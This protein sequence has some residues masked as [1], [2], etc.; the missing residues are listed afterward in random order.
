MEWP[1]D[2]T[3][4]GRFEHVITRT[5]PPGALS[6]VGDVDRTIYGLQKFMRLACNGNPSIIE[7][8]YTR[9][10][11]VEHPLAASLVVLAP[12]IVS[13]QAIPCFRGYMRSQALQLMGL[14]GRGRGART[15][16]RPELVELHGYDTKFAAHMV[17]LGFEGVELATTGR[18]TLPLKDQ[19][20]DACLDIR[21]GKWPVELALQTAFDLDAELKVLEKISVLPDAP[22]MVTINKWL[23]RAYELVWAEV[24]RDVD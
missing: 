10:R 9:D 16:A 5:Q 20:R 18:I 23:R 19:Y 15:G 12:E 8:L 17:R 7:V 24:E 6:G 14:V 13:K 2:I 11:I 4:L 3:G 22:N 1:H 21:A